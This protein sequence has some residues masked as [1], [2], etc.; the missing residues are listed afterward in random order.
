MFDQKKISRIKD[1]AE[2]YFLKGKFKEALS[3]YAQLK[4]YG[5]DDPRILL[6]IGDISRKAGDTPGQWRAT[7]RPPIYS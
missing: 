4:E 1:K 2:K 3:T 7:G 5:K 6:R